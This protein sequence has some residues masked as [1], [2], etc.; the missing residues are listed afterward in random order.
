M[1]LGSTFVHFKE[2]HIES[3]KKTVR[4]F[5]SAKD[6]VNLIVACN[7][8]GDKDDSLSIGKASSL[9]R[10]KNV[11]I[12]PIQNDFLTNA[13]MTEKNVWKLAQIL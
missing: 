6:R 2:I 9:K 8:N 13:R 4:G 5:K 12:L 1:K 3:C 10:F 11:K 7:V